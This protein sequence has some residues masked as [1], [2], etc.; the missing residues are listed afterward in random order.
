M[1]LSASLPQELLPAPEWQCCSGGENRCKMEKLIDS[2]S[3]LEAVFQLIA[4][5]F[6]F[7]FCFCFFLSLFLPRNLWYTLLQ[8][9][10][11]YWTNE[12]AKHITEFPG[13]SFSIAPN[14]SLQLCSSELTQFWALS[15]DSNVEQKCIC[16]W[17]SG[18]WL[19]DSY[20]V[21]WLVPGTSV[22]EAESCCGRL[23]KRVPC[24]GYR[25]F[26][27]EPPGSAVAGCVSD[28]LLIV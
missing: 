19:G 5:W 6:I 26:S 10:F 2:L 20:V 16:L 21:E 9:G 28:C 25:P 15:G 11:G 13:S 8:L 22:S 3:W 1:P 18:L 24:C 23:C 14:S 7:V 27:A 12:R 4:D 17:S